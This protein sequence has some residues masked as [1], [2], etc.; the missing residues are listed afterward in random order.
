MYRALT[1]AEHIIERCN[2]EGRPISNLK[3]QKILYFVQAEFWLVLDL[4]AFQRILK[5]GILDQLCRLFIID[6]RYMEV[7]I[8]HIFGLDRLEKS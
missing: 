7:L 5:H 3:L 8:Y 2:K 6:T 4:C 1:V